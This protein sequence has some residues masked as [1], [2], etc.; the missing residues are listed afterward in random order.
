M[1][2]GSILTPPSAEAELGHERQARADIDLAL[3]RLSEHGAVGILTIDAGF[4]AA[5]ERHHGHTAYRRS[6]SALVDLTRKSLEAHLMP[7]DM[8]IESDS[9]VDELLV[10]F[11]RPR[12]SLRFF[13]DVLPTLPKALSQF[14]TAQR[15]RLGHSDLV[16]VPAPCVGHALVLHSPAAQLR[17][18]LA[19]GI[20]R[21]RDDGDLFARLERQK[22]RHELT[23]MILGRDMEIVYQPIFE[24]A[25]R[26]VLG[27]EALLRVPPDGVWRSPSDVFVTAEREELIFELDVACRMAALRGVRNRLR[28]EEHLFLNTI[29]S[30]IHD[31]R[32]QR[33]QFG[34]L[35][36]SCGLE[37]RHIVVELSE[38]SC[39]RNLRAVRE[40]R[41]R[42]RAL[43]ISVALDD[44]GSSPSSISTL[45]DLDP[46][47]VK[48]DIALVR[49]SDGDVARQRLL[50]AV[51]DTVDAIGAASIAEGIETAAE[52]EALRTIG[53]RYGQGFHLGRPDRLEALPRA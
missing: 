37:P 7:S 26:K 33:G 46:E 18:E 9:R 53:V 52:L 45:M 8:V 50:R 21:A 1:A 16:D 31:P 10:L 6:T 11:F 15:H 19:I 43:G 3:R 12:S 2:S 5:V 36:A 17:R 34:H 29:P 49:S 40:A 41:E 24:L 30:A 51:Q 38:R 22:R 47:Y 28:H 35:L 20:E 23:R 48:I 27:Y 14:L 44:I 13:V 32:F 39:Q 4:L 25:T 42:L